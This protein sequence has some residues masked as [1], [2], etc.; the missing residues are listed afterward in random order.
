MHREETKRKM[1]EMRMDGA[2]YQEIGDAFGV[3]KQ[4]ANETIRRYMNKLIG[5]QRGKG[6]TIDDII[7]QGI[8][9]FLSYHPD[10]TISKFARECFGYD[11][12][13]YLQRTRNFITGKSDTVLKIHQI[14][15]ICDVCGVSFEECFKEWRR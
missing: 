2:S 10:M 1:L 9:D 4:S 13:E 15:K 7:Y 14:K 3:S 8:Y 11:N 5:T 12:P 6:L